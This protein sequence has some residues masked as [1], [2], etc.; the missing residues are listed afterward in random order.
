MLFNPPAKMIF[1]DNTTNVD[2]NSLVSDALTLTEFWHKISV[3]NECQI[4]ADNNIQ[5][6]INGRSEYQNLEVDENGYQIIDD[7]NIS[8]QIKSADEN[9]YQILSRDAMFC[10]SR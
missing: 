4:N 1:E 10:Y 5:M 2:D 7:D 6:P 9:G 3:E 8:M